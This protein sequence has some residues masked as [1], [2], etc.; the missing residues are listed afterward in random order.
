[1][2]ATGYRL[3]RPWLCGPFRVRGRLDLR[4][5]FQDCQAGAAAHGAGRVDLAGSKAAQE[6]AH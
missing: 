2:E 1:M 4:C 5:S 6:V 3:R